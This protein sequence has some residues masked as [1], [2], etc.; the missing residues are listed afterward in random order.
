ML[1]GLESVP[2]D[3]ISNNQTSVAGCDHPTIAKEMR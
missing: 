2:L 1:M 3:E